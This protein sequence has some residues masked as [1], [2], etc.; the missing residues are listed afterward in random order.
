MLWACVDALWSP[1]LIGGFLKNYATDKSH[2]VTL[3][4]E[5][6]DS[7]CSVNFWKGDFCV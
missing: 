1:M 4:Y 7:L 5:I 6:G 2:W 3:G